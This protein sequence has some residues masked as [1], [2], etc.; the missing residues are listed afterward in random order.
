MLTLENF[1]S[2]V[3]KQINRENQNFPHF[4]ATLPRLEFRDLDCFR[5]KTFHQILQAQAAMIPW[6]FSPSS[7]IVPNKEI[8]VHISFQIRKCQLIDQFEITIRKTH[9]FDHKKSY[10]NCD[11]PSVNKLHI[12]RMFISLSQKQNAWSINEQHCANSVHYQFR[13]CSVLCLV[14]DSVS[15][16]HLNRTLFESMKTLTN[17]IQIFGNQIVKFLHRCVS[18][19]IEENGIF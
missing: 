11:A 4:S 2:N 12:K 15:Q 6:V 3:Y 18:K 13:Y 17:L 8:F 5:S 1:T 9:D 7:T 14:I 10:R 16:L 19:Y